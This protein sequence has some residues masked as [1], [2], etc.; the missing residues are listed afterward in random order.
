MIKHWSSTQK[1]VTLSSGEAE[2]VGIVRGAAEAQGFRSLVS[3][4]GIAAQLRLYAESAAAIGTCRRSGIGNVRHL[5]TGQLWVQER[6]RN[7]DFTVFKIP[8][9][10]N[11][12][13]ILSKAVPREVL[14]KHLVVLGFTRGQGR[15]NS[16]PHLVRTGGSEA[17]GWREQG[18]LLGLALLL[19]GR[20]LL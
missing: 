13:D 14:D 4:L 1:A 17:V 16:A 10:E 11:P 5:A 9:A 20:R 6:L 3:D 12:V 18:G 2:F 15:A 7:G 8:G 19:C